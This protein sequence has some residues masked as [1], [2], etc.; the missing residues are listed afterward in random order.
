MST[1]RVSVTGIGAK[2]FQ[3]EKWDTQKQCCEASWE[4]LWYREPIVQP[5]G[6]EGDNGAGRKGSRLLLASEAVLWTER[7]IGRS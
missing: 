5:K 7:L 6:E 2:S 4:V 3:T 1:H